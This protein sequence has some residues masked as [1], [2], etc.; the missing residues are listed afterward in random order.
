MGIL[1]PN[2]RI[3]PRREDLLAEARARA[4]ALSRDYQPPAPATIELRHGAMDRHTLRGLRA[5]HL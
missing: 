3:N 5:R 1:R 2:D 4:L